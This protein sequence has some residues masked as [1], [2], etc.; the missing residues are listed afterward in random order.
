[1]LALLKDRDGQLLVRD[2]VRTASN[3]GDALHHKLPDL[4]V[5]WNDVAFVPG[6]RIDDTDFEAQHAG[7]KTGQHALDGFCIIRG[8]SELPSRTSIRAE[9]MGS[10]MSEMLL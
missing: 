4:V 3:E 5:H 1:M 6:L 2:V 7:I 8:D 9:E 10:L